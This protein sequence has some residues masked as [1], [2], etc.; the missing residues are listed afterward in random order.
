MDCDTEAQLLAQLSPTVSSQRD[1]MDILHLL[2]RNIDKCLGHL[3]P[4]VANYGS[5]P[6]QTYL[7]CGDLDLTIILASPQRDEDLLRTVRNQM[8]FV[9]QIRPQYD[10]KAFCE[11]NAEVKVLKF[12][13]KGVPVDISVNQVGGLLTLRL[14]ELVDSL[15]A[16]H[17][18]KRALLVTKAWA[19]Y[20]SRIAGSQ[21]GLLASYALGVL[22]ICTLNSC[23]ASRT[24]PIQ[25]LIH[26]IRTLSDIDWEESVITCYGV[27]RV[28]DYMQG[29]RLGR[30]REQKGLF[31]AKELELA[32]ELEQGCRAFQRKY[33]NLADPMKPDNNLGRSVSRGNAER[34]KLAFKAAA[35]RLTLQGQAGLFP[36]LCRVRTKAGPESGRTSPSTS[37]GSEEEHWQFT[38][39][40]EAVERAV[41]RAQAV[42][43]GQGGWSKPWMAFRPGFRP[44]MER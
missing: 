15:T 26:M 19:T 5:F 43:E 40:L 17:L 7:P 34:L 27:M 13:V 37:S 16:D 28:Q 3:R 38:S 11:V 35:Q 12:V 6:L 1:R 9:A 2:R 14:F 30:M 41:Q 29:D 33:V 39:E 23:P 31:C 18:F 24:S 25:V 42:A 4:F 10:I 22:V 32:G 44:R 8:E 20:E 36:S 21:Y